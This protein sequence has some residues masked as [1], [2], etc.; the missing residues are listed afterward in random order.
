[1]FTRFRAAG[2]LAVAAGITMVLG[3]SGTAGAAD[4]GPRTLS[5]GTGQV[6]VAT[7]WEHTFYDG[8][9]IYFYAEDCRSAGRQPLDSLPDGWNDRLSSLQ[10][11]GQCSVRLYEHYSRQ[12]RHVWHNANSRIPDLWGYNDRTSSMLFEEPIQ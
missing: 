3:L 11:Y 9:A 7:G 1:M 2:A 5:V 10:I 6:H 12:G 4:A 8:A